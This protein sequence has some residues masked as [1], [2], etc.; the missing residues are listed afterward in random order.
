M[1]FLGLVP[2]EHSSGEKRRQGKITKTGNG[3]ARRVLVEAAQ[4]YCHPARVMRYLLKRLEGI[5][6]EIRDIAWKCQTRLCA[7]FR[8]LLAKGKNRNTIVTA[9]ARE[10]AAFMW[11]IA[12]QTP[13]TAWQFFQRPEAKGQTWNSHNIQSIYGLRTACGESSSFLWDKVYRTPAPRQWQLRDEDKSCGIQ[14]A[15]IRMIKRRN[16]GS[17]PACALEITKQHSHLK[18]RNG[19]LYSAWQLTTIS[20]TA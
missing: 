15:N 10:L 1:A 8:R 16:T 14:P 12:K 9:I 19:K 6:Q 5:V 18:K 20:K 3:H 2:S 13:I 7:R 11:A 4:S 17:V